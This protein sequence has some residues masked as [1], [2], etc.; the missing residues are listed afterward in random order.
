MTLQKQIRDLIFFYIKTNYNQYLKD[1]HISMIP[2]D[3]I[4]SVIHSLYDERKEHLKTFIKNSL[5]KIY[6]DNYPGDLA[7][8]NIL[9]N[10]F[11]DD[12]LC[13]NRLKS[14]IILHQ[15]SIQGEKNDY[16]KIS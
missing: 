13:K 10:I 7:V 15:Q 1:N 11:D 16:S 9:M 4:E 6:N 8:L 5:K 12:N 14:E 2:D 3:K